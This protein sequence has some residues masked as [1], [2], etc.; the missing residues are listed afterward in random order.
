[1]FCTGPLSGGWHG[2]GMP[3]MMFL[4]PVLML[5]FMFLAC[6]FFRPGFAHWHWRGCRP[7]AGG[8]HDE[9][10]RLLRQE[11]EELRRDIKNNQ[12]PKNP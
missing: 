4:M 9:E 7:P 10:I 6:R 1:M 3:W 11:L 2:W 8:F 5:A 12:G